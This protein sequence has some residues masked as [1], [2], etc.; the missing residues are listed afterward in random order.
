MLLP[1]AIY[2]VNT[3]AAVPWGRFKVV[4]F[5][6]LGMTGAQ[7]GAVRS[8]THVA[9]LVAWPL[10]GLIS[11]ITGS[12]KLTLIASLILATLALEM[13]RRVG[14][15]PELSFGLML[16]CAVCRS[17]MNAEW[18]LVDAATLAMVQ[19]HQLSSPTAQPES[20]GKQRL[21]AAIAWGLS[22]LLVGLSIDS[23]GLQIVFLLTYIAVAA[24]LM[25]VMAWLPNDLRHTKQDDP[26]PQSKAPWLSMKMGLF[27]CNL[28]MISVVHA[29]PEQVIFLHL[30]KIG[31]SRT[32][33]GAATAA[34]VIFEIPVFY[35]SDA[36]IKKWGTQ[37]MIA[38]AQVALA[39]R[40]FLYYIVPFD[41]PWLVVAA[42]SLHG[43]SFGM[44][45]SAAVP[46]AQSLAPAGR[47]VFIQSLL[48]TIWGTVG[49]AI[50]SISWGVVCDMYGPQVTYLWGGVVTLTL[51]FVLTLPP[52]SW[53][54]P[55]LASSSTTS[56]LATPLCLPLDQ[57][58]ASSWK[59]SPR[60]SLLY[61]IYMG[62]HARKQ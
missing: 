28:L 25:L 38:R 30:E 33:Q 46:Y 24:E 55:I 8:A 19:K 52:W 57:E 31:A 39:I 53:E 42:Q 17:A 58:L 11:D 6:T 32:L 7:V 23:N 34:T 37:G 49:Q 48:C 41:Q 43:F 47:E 62:G 3:C 61:V 29:I 2:F 15:A 4:Y 50:G 9:K 60:L 40:M 22:S 44:M 12:I 54:T 18:P 36:L 35:H 10:W 26:A 16:C 51:L 5:S 20:Y 45:W 56:A 59:L 14:S 13:L 1:K 21:W 27:F